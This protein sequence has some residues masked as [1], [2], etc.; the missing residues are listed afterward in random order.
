[1]RNDERWHG[2]CQPWFMA[3]QASKSSLSM[4]F[5][6]YLQGRKN[7][8]R[9]SYR[10]VLFLGNLTSLNTC[11]ATYGK[12]GRDA[13]IPDEMEQILEPLPDQT[14]CTEVPIF[15]A[16]QLW[17]IYLSRWLPSWSTLRQQKNKPATWNGMAVCNMQLGMAGCWAGYW[18]NALPPVFRHSSFVEQFPERSWSPRHWDY[19]VTDF[20]IALKRCGLHL[21]T[22]IKCSIARIEHQH[23]SRD[24]SFS[25]LTA[26]FS[27]GKHPSCQQRS[28][29]CGGFHKWGYP[30]SSS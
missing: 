24:S 15:L 4:D 16:R 10:N 19:A 9:Q 30:Q 22:T 26:L 8:C 14:V 11:C 6:R 28:T 17:Q 27:E 2:R 1:M 7:P 23:A 29:S 12:Y 18:M 13:R 21:H 20:G 3:S 5:E 25:R